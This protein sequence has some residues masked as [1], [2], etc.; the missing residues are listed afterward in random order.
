MTK[1]TL[2][3]DGVLQAVK[4]ENLSITATERQLSEKE[5]AYIKKHVKEFALNT[6]KIEA[7]DGVAWQ[8]TGADYFFDTGYIYG[9]DLEKIA[10]ILT[11]KYGKHIQKN[12]SSEN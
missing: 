9:S 3:G 2:F 8:F 6:E 4:F 5:L 7:F 10:K 12:S 1:Y 11:G